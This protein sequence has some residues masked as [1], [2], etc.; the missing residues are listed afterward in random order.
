MLSYYYNYCNIRGYQN[1][2]RGNQYLL[3]LY[4]FL[5]QYFPYFLCYTN[6]PKV[7]SVYCLFH[8]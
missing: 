6:E 8:Q 7:A 4:F 3:I 2:E 5:K 1:F